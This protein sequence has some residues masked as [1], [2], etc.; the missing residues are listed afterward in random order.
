MIDYPMWIEQEAA[1]QRRELRD[2]QRAKILGEQI[3]EVPGVVNLND[4]AQAAAFM[5]SIEKGTATDGDQSD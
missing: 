5:E 2:N 1:T 3:P 4:P